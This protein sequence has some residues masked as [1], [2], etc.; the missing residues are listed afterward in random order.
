MQS[1]KT[2]PAGVHLHFG[3]KLFLAANT[4]YQSEN[5]LQCLHFQT[6]FMIVYFSQSLLKNDSSGAIR[7]EDGHPKESLRF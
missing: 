4:K 6:G 3:N 5:N 7:Q 1:C 2:S